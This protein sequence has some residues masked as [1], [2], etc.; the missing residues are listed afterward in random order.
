M[1]AFVLALAAGA[2]LLSSSPQPALAADLDKLRAAL[3]E[4]LPE[5]KIERVRE[6]HIKDL[7]EV[8]YNGREILYSDARGEL[9][10][11]GNLYDLKTRYNLT[12]ES[13]DTLDKVDFGALPLDKAIVKKVGDGSRRLAIFSDPDCP[14]CQRLEG[15]LAKLDNVTLYTFL[16]PLRALHPDAARKATLV[17]C[18]PDPVK[19]WDDLMLRQ[20]EPAAAKRECE[21]PIEAITALAASSA[22]NGTPGIVFPSGR[23]VQGY[24]PAERI[25]QLLAPANGS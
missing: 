5:L 18:S 3:A 24:I 17:W 10:L 20:I 11:M 6:S 1:K 2:V 12:Q 21:A 16:Y 4:R 13:K 14:F 15:E 7:Y 25:E 9:A 22:I 19:A 23:L 8:V